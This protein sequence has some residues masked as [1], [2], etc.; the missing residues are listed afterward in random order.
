MKFDVDSSSMPVIVIP[1]SMAISKDSGVLSGSGGTGEGGLSFLE[2]TEK[3]TGAVRPPLIF[4]SIDINFQVCI[5]LTFV[6][7]LR[8]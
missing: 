2:E 3:C 4:A 8:A 5:M 7:T 6:H 1:L